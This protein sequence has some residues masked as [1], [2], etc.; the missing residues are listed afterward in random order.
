MR[1]RPIELTRG[2]FGLALL[3]A[4]RRMLQDV[5][6]VEVDTRSVAVARILGARQLAQAGLSGAS[7]SPEVLALG[8]WVDLAHGATA[9]ALAL[10]DPSRAFAGLLNAAVA[11]TWAGWGTVDLRRGAV[12][13]SDHEHRRDA[14]ASWSLARL[15]G[16]SRLLRL[17]ERRRTR[18]GLTG[19][20]HH[21]GLGGL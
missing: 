14:L 15:P 5:H 8:I 16:G 18:L 7:P 3:V 11:T 10:V 12:T 19:P 2:A 21:D 9:V 6:R 17:V 13:P 4:P 20:G 1:L